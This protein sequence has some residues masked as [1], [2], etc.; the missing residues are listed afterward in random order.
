LRIYLSHFQKST[1]KNFPSPPREGIHPVRW[2]GKFAP[3]R[4]KKDL[5]NRVKGRGDQIFSIL[6]TPTLTLPRQKGEGIIREISN[7]FV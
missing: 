1:I 4:L 2:I 3:S 6:S 5:S 7:I